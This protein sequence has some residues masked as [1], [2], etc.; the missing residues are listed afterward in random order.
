MSLVAHNQL[1]LHENDLSQWQAAHF[2]HAL[3]EIP[4]KVCDNPI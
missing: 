2:L 1:A 3:N 4:H